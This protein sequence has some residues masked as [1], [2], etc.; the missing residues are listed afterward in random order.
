MFLPGQ[1]LSTGPMLLP[2]VFPEVVF[3][4]TPGTYVCPLGPNLRQQTL[5][6][7]HVELV[8]P[9]TEQR[10]NLVLCSRPDPVNRPQL[11]SVYLTRKAR[12]IKA[13]KE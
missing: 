6:L 2:F 12:L 5:Y 11:G 10:P 9:V 13:V 3:V 8:R 1:L 4:S 7:L